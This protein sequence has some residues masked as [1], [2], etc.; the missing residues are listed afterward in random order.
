MDNYTAVSIAEGFCDGKPTEEEQIEAWQH[1]IDTGLCRTLQG[2][3][4]RAAEELIRAGICHAANER[5]DG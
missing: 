3:F 1:L 2:W 4:G 5:V